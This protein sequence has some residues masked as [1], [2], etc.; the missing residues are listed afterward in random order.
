MVTTEQ[1]A[2]VATSIAA[3]TKERHADRRSWD[4][5]H[6]QW[7]VYGFERQLGFGG[8]AGLCSVVQQVWRKPQEEIATAV[9]GYLCTLYRDAKK[10][11]E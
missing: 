5:T 6:G 10:L 7:L 9:L 1:L 3:Q 8:S 4:K 11:A 2:K